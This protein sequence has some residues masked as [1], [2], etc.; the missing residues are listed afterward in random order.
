MELIEM[1][2]LNLNAKL[3]TFA[4]FDDSIANVARVPGVA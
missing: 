2:K 3:L 1:E 4:K